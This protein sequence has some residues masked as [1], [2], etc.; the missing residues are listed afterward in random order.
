MG[1]PSL[2]G[3]WKSDHTDIRLLFGPGDVFR[4]EDQGGEKDFA[5]GLIR[6]Q[7]R[8]V[9]FFNRAGSGSAAAS[10]SPGSY[11]YQIEGELL[12]FKKISDPN[13]DRA[14][15]LVGTWEKVSSGP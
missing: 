4:M 9:T 14:K 7:G 3:T 1:S 5:S 10:S 11:M 6:F 13:L 8:E 12:A 15:I 2:S